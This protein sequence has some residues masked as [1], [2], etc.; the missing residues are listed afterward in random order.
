M[1]LSKT[2][3]QQ[4]RAL[5]GAWVSDDKHGFEGVRFKVRGRY[6]PD[7]KSLEAR[8]GAAVPKDKKLQNGFLLPEE[9]DRIVTELLIE[10]I[11]VDW[12]GVREDDEAPAIPYSKEEARKLLSDP[13]LRPFR[14]SALLAALVVAEDGK[15]AIE[16]DA[17]N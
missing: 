6:N 14:D 5:N 8:L 13:L 12:D 11:L 3:K 1:S 4:T 16:E 17:K 7:A 9:S 10:T 2:R 15:D